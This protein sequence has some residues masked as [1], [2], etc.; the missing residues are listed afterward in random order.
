MG[1]LDL[2]SIAEINSCRIALPSSQ[3]TVGGGPFSRFPL[4]LSSFPFVCSFCSVTPGKIQTRFVV[5]L[6]EQMLSRCQRENLPP[7]PPRRRQLITSVAVV[8]VDTCTLAVVVAA[9]ASPLPA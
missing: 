8:F 6:L 1:F 5:V 9:A 3:A 2:R 4:F 7:L